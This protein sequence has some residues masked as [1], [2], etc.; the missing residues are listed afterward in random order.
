[1]SDYRLDEIEAPD[2]HRKAVQR[3]AGDRR[4][5]RVDHSGGELPGRKLLGRR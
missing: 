1:M 2:H 5:Q 4:Q 3:L